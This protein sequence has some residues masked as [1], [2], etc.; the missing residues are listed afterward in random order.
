ML[1]LPYVLGRGTT[2]DAIGFHDECGEEGD[3][4]WPPDAWADLVLVNFE[5]LIA[6][7]PL[8]PPDAAGIRWV[9]GPLGPA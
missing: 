3:V 9:G 1:Q 4:D 6:T 2:S 8:P 7:Q 5:E